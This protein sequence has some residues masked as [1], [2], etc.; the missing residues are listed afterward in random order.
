MASAIGMLSAVNLL[1]FLKTVIN[2]Q[3]HKLLLMS[4][5]KL[6]LKRSTFLNDFGVFPRG[7]ATGNVKGKILAKYFKLCTLQICAV[8]IQVLEGFPFFFHPYS[9]SL[10]PSFST[11]LFTS[12]QTLL[13]PLTHPSLFSLSSPFLKLDLKRY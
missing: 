5:N 12:M 2:A 6:S 11:D 10:H 13:H 3:K 4:S 9:L 1:G 7:Q 8:S